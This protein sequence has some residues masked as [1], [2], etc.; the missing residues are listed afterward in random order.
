M[1]TPCFSVALVP[2]ASAAAVGAST[3]TTVTE[4]KRGQH[5]E[6]S[7]AATQQSSG[8]TVD[9]SHM[10]AISSLSPTVCLDVFA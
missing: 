7:S 3:T 10:E 8:P 1:L 9:T 4:E 5:H 2:D 6:E